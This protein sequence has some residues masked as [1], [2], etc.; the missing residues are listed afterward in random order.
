PR[1]A[2]S[3]LAFPTETVSGQVM[4]E[5]LAGAMETLAEADVALIGGHSIK[6]E[7]A[8]L[9]FAITGLVEDGRAVE[10]AGAAVG[11]MLVLTKPLGVGVLTFA[12]QIGRANAEGLAAATES[13]ATLNR[14]AAEAMREVGVS[15]C[16]DVTGFGLFG[17]LVGMVRHAGMTAEIWADALPAFPGAIEGLREGVVPGA[18]ER[19]MEYVGEDIRVD[20]PVED[21]RVDLGFD[22]QT[23]G[24]LLIA[25]PADKHTG[26]CE[27]LASRGVVAAT[28]GRIAGESEGEIHV[29]AAPSEALAG[30]S[31]APAKAPC[32]ASSAES[33]PDSDQPKP[34]CSGGADADK[35]ADKPAAGGVA[36]ARRAFGSLIRAASG[37]GAVDANTKELITFALA[38][39]S[40]CEP[41]VAAHV[42]AARE[43][44]L[45][46]DQLDEAAWCAIAMGGAPVR[47]FYEEV[48]SD[49]D[50]DG[51]CCCPQ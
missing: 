33:R 4:Y 23:S 30:R 2:L 51:D 5:M 47:M 1:T 7:E 3:V 34:C 11:D 12:A 14:A 9:G 31:P 20:E 41:C 8:K 22:A 32:C 6:D 24:G 18:V 38:V 28:V 25:V 42:T 21:A 49:G 43:M 27:A 48:R 15:A 26:L 17:H 40:R 45:T 29:T 39:L 50:A 16:T 10:R 44:G 35:D 37:A 19:N 13:M 36:E 46:Q